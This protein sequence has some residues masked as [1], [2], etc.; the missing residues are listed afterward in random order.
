MAQIFHHSTNV[1]A[2]LS[3]VGVVTAVPVVGTLAFFFNMN[4]G[5]EVRQPKAQPVQFSHKHHVGDDGIDCRYCHSTVDK[6]ASAGMPS[7][8]T[9]MSCHSQLWVDSPELEIVRNAYRTGRPISW[10]RVHDLPDFAYF[11]HSIH[12]NKGVSCV[13]C[14]GRIDEMPQ[15]YKDKTLTMQWCLD[16]HR[17]PEK[18]LRPKEFVYDLAWKPEDLSPETHAA[19]GGH[20]DG[21]HAE[22]APPP[23]KAAAPVKT[24]KDLVAEYHILS[25]LQLTSCSTCHR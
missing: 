21:A 20:G 4:Y 17:S 24:G 13:S 7:T 2:K 8:H 10:T 16:C 18:N 1:L 3:I 5:A 25:T 23:P 9:C 19:N 15:V 6:G 22:G 12:V 14:H 11:D